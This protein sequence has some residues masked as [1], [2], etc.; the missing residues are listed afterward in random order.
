MSDAAAPLPASRAQSTRKSLSAVSSSRKASTSHRKRAKSLASANP[1]EL[2]PRSLRRRSLVPKK[3]I[4]KQSNA[5]NITAPLYGY[6]TSQL[7]FQ[8]RQGSEEPTQNLTRL[9][10]F[11]GDRRV[12]FAPNAHVRLIPKESQHTNGSGSPPSSPQDSDTSSANDSQENMRPTPEPSPLKN[13]KS[14]RRSSLRQS[15]GD[16]EGEE[17]MDLAS[18]NSYVEDEQSAESAAD[19][20]LE[21]DESVVSQG[22]SMDME[23]QVDMDITMNTNVTGRLSLAK[24]RRSSTRPAGRRSSTAPR[25]REEGKPTEYTVV[26]EES[27]KGEFQPTATWLALKAVTNSADNRPMPSEGDLDIETAAQR[28]LMAGQDIPLVANDDGEADM[29]LS[30]NADSAGSPGAKMMNLTSLIGGIRRASAAAVSAVIDVAAPIISPSKEPPATPAPDVRPVPAAVPSIFTQDQNTIPVPATP[31]SSIPVPA[32][33]PGT[34]ASIFR[35]KQTSIFTPKSGQT[36]DETSWILSSLRPPSVVKPKTAFTVN[37]PVP[38]TPKTPARQTP[39][40]RP[41]PADQTSTVVESPA[42]RLAVAV[43]GS[44]QAKPVPRVTPNKSAILSSPI[45]RPAQSRTPQV[46]SK[47]TTATPSTPKP[48]QKTVAPAS[49]SSPSAADEWPQETVEIPR[50]PVG[51]VDRPTSPVLSPAQ[52][53]SAPETPKPPVEPISPAIEATPARSIAETANDT[54]ARTPLARRSEVLLTSPWLSKVQRPSMAISRASDD[55]GEFDDEGE[56]YG[57]TMTLA[58]LDD[59]ARARLPRSIDELLKLV[60]GEFMDNMAARRRSTMALRAKD[61]YPDTPPT[62][63]DFANAIVIDYPQLSYY[64][65]VVKHLQTYI[66]QLDKQQA[67]INETVVENPPPCFIDFATGGPDTLPELKLMLE[68]LRRLVRSRTKLQWYRWRY[69]GVS[70]LINT[71]ETREKAALVD[72]TQTRALAPEVIANAEIIEAEHAAIMAELE[73]ERAVVAEIEKCDAKELA[74]LKADI[75]MNNTELKALEQEI[76]Q[77]QADIEAITQQ[78]NELKLEQKRLQQRM[79]TANRICASENCERDAFGETRAAIE[80]LENVSGWKA[81]KI[82][83]SIVDLEYINQYTVHIPCKDWVPIVD[84]CT[85]NLKKQPFSKSTRTSDWLP[86]FTS[87]TLECARQRLVKGKFGRRS[88]RKIMGKLAAYWSSCEVVRQEILLL[89]SKFTVTFK[90]DGK[91]LHTRVSLLFKQTCAKAVI[92]FSLTGKQIEE[93]PQSMQDV[94]VQAEKVYVLEEQASIS[95]TALSEAVLTYIKSVS[96]QE[97]FGVLLDACME[98]EALYS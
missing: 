15:I 48:A 52:T 29:T 76:F 56:E 83:S 98:A 62:I 57:N 47:T 80:L 20:S 75:A 24:P 9:S 16:G 74:S 73:R 18:E 86:E 91:T 44:S 70:D 55:E 3:S 11:N 85:I 81:L 43:E 46:P 66:D 51:Q 19:M 10:N 77:L 27:L 31:A 84:Q 8:Q 26:L 14:S 5:A 17:S 87:F 69:E 13:Y 50:T 25:P 60:G 35:P 12:S 65:F 42:K 38:G 32:A 79:E 23:S 61:Q 97:E 64:D 89:R 21:N 28:M 41:H 78:E 6:T 58:M 45:K 68:S 72:L 22:S 34:A 30:S 49:P 4:L 88:V 96:S 82:S 67:E 33:T 1:E 2:T 71:V 95:E 40:K 63:G 54:P 39:M 53:P 93:W 90:A 94:A 7:D 59:E 37:V 36:T 92:D